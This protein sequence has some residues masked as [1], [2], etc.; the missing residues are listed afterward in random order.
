MPVAGYMTE[1][2]AL[3]LLLTPLFIGAATLAGRR[4]GPAVGGWLAGFPWTSAPVAL[5]LALEQDRAFTV[6]AGVGIILG[7]VAL[8][9]F[10]L[11]YGWMARSAGWLASLTASFLT[12]VVLTAAF[13]KLAPPALV[14]FGGVILL[15]SIIY[16]LLPSAGGSDSPSAPPRWDLPLRMLTATAVVFGLTEAAALL[17]PHLT[18]LI[19]PLPVFAGV[20]T[21]FTHQ[22]DGPP[23]AVRLVRGIVLGTYT[24]AVFFLIIALGL[25]AWGVTITFGLAAGAALLVHAG[26]LNVV[27]REPQRN[28]AGLSPHS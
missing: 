23:A 24:F 10:C 8:C 21:T 4:W 15:I 5:F 9:G 11:V 13:T 1:T 18:G 17:G 20:L 6:R 27:V 12:Y 16:R 28:R 22:H 14:A 2:T 19:T 25:E 7:L 3:K 26:L